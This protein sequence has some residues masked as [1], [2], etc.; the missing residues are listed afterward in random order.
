MVFDEKIVKYPFL[1]SLIESDIEISEND[2]ALFA[3]EKTI[4]DSSYSHMVALMRKNKGGFL[5]EIAYGAIK[6]G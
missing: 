1:A 2:E 4:K 3:F 6:R 5:R